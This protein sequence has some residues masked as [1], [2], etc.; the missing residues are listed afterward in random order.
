MKEIDKARI[1]LKIK[2]MEE[3]KN[4][5][6]MEER[7]LLK[8]ES[9]QKDALEVEGKVVESKPKKSQKK[10][11]LEEPS[12]LAEKMTEEQKEVTKF[13]EKLGYVLNKGL[14][15]Y[16]LY[17]DIPSDEWEQPI[18]NWVNKLPDGK[19]F[20]KSQTIIEKVVE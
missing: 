14:A 19:A 9:K 13:A 16:L 11:E 8:Y 6:P 7:I 20:T 18:P 15:L 4:K 1:M 17:G 3:V 5:V 10:L 2:M 12:L